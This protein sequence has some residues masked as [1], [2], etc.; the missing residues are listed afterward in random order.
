M[1]HCPL[2]AVAAPALLS[3]ESEGR[4]GVGVAMSVLEAA[5]SPFDVVNA[6]GVADSEVG[7]DEGCAARGA[8]SLGGVPANVAEAEAGGGA[9]APSV[10]EA[11]SVGAA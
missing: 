2:V 10:L 1:R 6:V 8:E 11:C 7:D 3:L 9:G 4:L 5:N